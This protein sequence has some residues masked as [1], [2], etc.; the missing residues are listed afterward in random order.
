MSERS[1]D[2]ADT[3]NPRRRRA[4]LILSAILMLAVVAG[5]L[6]WVLDGRYHETTDDAYVSGDIIQITPQ[7][8]GMVLAIHADDT[9]VVK[10]GA[11]LVE[12]DPAD[13]RIALD[14]AEAALAQAVR[15]VRTLYAT[16]GS[17]GAV[18][19]QREADLA[20]ARDDLRRRQALAGT[21]AVSG[22]EIEHARAGVAASEAALATARDQLLSNQALSDHTTVENH[23]NVMRAAARVEEACLALKRSS[24]TAPVA[25]QVAKR[26]VQVGTRVAPGQPLMAIVPLDR[27]WVDA[28]FKEGQLRQ[29]RVGQPVALAAD[30]YGSRVRYTGKVVG[31]GAGT[32]A[33]FSLLPAQNATGNWI[34]IVQR[35]PVR[36]ALDPGQLAEHPLRVG[37]SMQADVDVHDQ[38][39]SQLAAGRREAVARAAEP[40]GRDE[41]QKLVRRIIAANLEGASAPR[42]NT[43]R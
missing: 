43:G 30:I 31:L 26:G 6:W 23:P 10:A 42:R 25:G 2:Q 15:E 20:K 35:L 33:A 34:K 11:P 39:G 40:A 9:D 41:A 24:I 17:L 21:G 4:L 3:P 1:L 18:V 14:Q 8:A 38:G 22:E 27:V 32:G 28:N 12:L 29:M 16:N 7:T 19:A 5:G 36:V 13:A 37:L